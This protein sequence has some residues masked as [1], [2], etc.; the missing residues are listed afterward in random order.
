MGL[1]EKEVAIL[2]RMVKMVDYGKG[3]YWKWMDLCQVF[4]KKENVTF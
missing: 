4:Q 3:Q 1:T 2:A